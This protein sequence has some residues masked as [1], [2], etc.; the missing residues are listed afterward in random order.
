MEKIIVN[1][2]NEIV[3]IAQDGAN[4]YKTLADSVENKDIATVF[5]RLSQQRK[6]F[7]EEL[8]YECLV[9]GNE[10]D[11]TGTVKG[12]FHRVFMEI[13]SIVKSDDKLIDFAVQGE[14]KAIEVYESMITLEVP[15]YLREKL[16]TQL[17]L[18]KGAVK[19]L[20]HF[21]SLEKQN[22]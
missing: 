17:G 16:K 7:V 20:Q 10:L 8:K 14:R 18:I 21:K 3:D 19:Q 6:M 12:F 2:I 11:I 9:Q 1:K 4:G 15:R 13:Q 5:L 22:A